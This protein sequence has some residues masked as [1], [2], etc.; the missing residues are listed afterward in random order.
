MKEASSI[1]IHRQLIVVYDDC[2]V[3]TLHVTKWCRVCKWLDNYDNHTSQ[4]KHQ[5][6]MRT[7]HKWKNSFWKTNESQ[8]EDSSTALELSIKLHKTLTMKVRA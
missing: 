3:S 4:L 6:R 1:K 2:T 8:L 7:Q 5:G